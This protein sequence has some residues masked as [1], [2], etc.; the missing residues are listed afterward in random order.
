MG[1]SLKNSVTPDEMFADYGA[2]TLR[3]YEMSMGPLEVSRPGRPG[4][5]SGPSASS[6]GCGAT[7]STR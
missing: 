2:D 5:S 4:R 3:V 1:K 7:S 6:S